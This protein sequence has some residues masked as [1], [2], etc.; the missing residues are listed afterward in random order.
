MKSVRLILLISLLVGLQGCLNTRLSPYDIFFYALSH[1]GKSVH[2]GGKAMGY[3]LNLDTP[4]M[5][6]AQCQQLGSL[7]NPLRQYPVA[8][9]NVS[10]PASQDADST[11]QFPE[12][13]WQVP[14][15]IHGDFTL[16]PTTPILLQV[17]EDSSNPKASYTGGINGDAVI[18]DHGRCVQAGPVR[19]VCAES[20]FKLLTLEFDSNTIGQLGSMGTTTAR[21]HLELDLA[22][23]DDTYLRAAF[24]VKVSQNGQ[25]YFIPALTN[26]NTL[27]DAPRLDLSPTNGDTNAYP[28]FAHE[29]SAEFVNVVDEG[30]YTVNSGISGSWYDPEFDGQG[31]NLQMLSETLALA[32]WFSYD[33]R[34]NQAW[35]YGLGEVSGNSITFSQLRQPEGGRFGNNFDPNQVSQPLWGTMTMIFDD[36]SSGY[37]VYGGKRGFDTGEMNIQRLTGLQSISCAGKREPTTAKAIG[38]EMNGP[39]YDPSHNGEGWLLEILDDSTAVAYWFTYDRNGNQAWF[40]GVGSISGDDIQFD[41]VYRPTGARFGMNSYN[42]SQVNRQT[43]GSM[44]FT[45]SDC[46]NGSMTYDLSA[47][48]FGTGSLQLKKIAN[49]LGSGCNL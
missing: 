41:T 6:V 34:G 9:C 4:N 28:W 30:E 33:E 11:V 12:F 7:G 45:F 31:W 43:A 2:P 38:A 46:A 47:A 49:I 42:P 22:N 1:G 32:Y 8:D 25:D 23:D 16:D 26:G 17:P 39:W 19:Q 21:F 35:F 37:T 5:Y 18:T 24:A 48:G 44:R 3:R 20:G 13:S 40:V 27:A 14:I 15:R 36:C 10:I 29:A